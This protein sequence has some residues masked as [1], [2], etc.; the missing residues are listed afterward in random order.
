MF[1]GDEMFHVDCFRCEQCQMKIEEPV[2]V[3]TSQVIFYFPD[4][5]AI[6]F[7]DILFAYISALGSPVNYEGMEGMDMV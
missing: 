6:S 7:P 1:K 2:F 4:C 5:F 3:K